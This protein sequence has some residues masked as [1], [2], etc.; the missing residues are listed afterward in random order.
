MEKGNDKGMEAFIWAKIIPSSVVPVV[1]ISACGL[2]CL[3]FYNRLAY[4][5]TRLRSLQRERLAEYK[6]IFQLEKSHASDLRRQQADQF[7][8]FLEGQTVDVLKRARYLQRCIFWLIYCIGSLV[9]TSLLI[10]L[11]LFFPALDLVV[12]FFYVTGFLALLYGLSFA[13]REILIA[14]RPI[15]A[16]S[17][18]VQELIKSELN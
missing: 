13:V 10:A 1:I 2:L 15:Q 16:E 11:S 9:L 5:V 8:Q 7:L 12:L 17:G 6:E 3:A 14:L 18:F 4:I